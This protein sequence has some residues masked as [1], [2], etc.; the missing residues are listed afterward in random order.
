MPYR[1]NQYKEEASVP[2]PIRITA[3]IE[4]YLESVPTDASQDTTV[5]SSDLER[6]LSKIIIDE[7]KPLGIF[8]KLDPRHCL[9]LFV[10]ETKVDPII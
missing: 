4:L 6:Y 5:F 9:A 3:E 7:G 1:T 10:K 8:Y 2:R